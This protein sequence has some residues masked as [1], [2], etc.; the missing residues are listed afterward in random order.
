MDSPLAR[1]NGQK[2]VQGTAAAAT[3]HVAGKVRVKKGPRRLNKQSGQ[4]QAAQQQRQQQSAKQKP[5]S[6]TREELDAEMDEYYR[7]H[8]SGGMKVQG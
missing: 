4:Q 5:T 8:E 1:R 6:K 7:A 2:K 3:P